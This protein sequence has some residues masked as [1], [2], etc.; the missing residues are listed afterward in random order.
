MQIAR[1]NKLYPYS[2][3]IMVRGRDDDHL[4]DVI[5]MVNTVLVSN[6][7][8][9]IDSEYDLFCLDRYMRC[10]PAALTLSS[11][12]S[13]CATVSS[14]PITWPVYYRFMAVVWVQATPGQVH[15]N[16]GGEPVCFDPTY[17]GD[18]VKMDTCFYLDR[19]DPVSPQHWSICS[20][21]SPRSLI[22]DGL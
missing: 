6:N 17:S 1:G 7:F 19:R 15:F 8:K 5:Q 10:I 16:R 20:C 21:I 9:I 3:N 11:R 4:D 13:K 22:L 12:N 14:T 2:M 18:R